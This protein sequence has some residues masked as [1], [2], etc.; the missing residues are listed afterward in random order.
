[1]LI[2]NIVFIFCR[3]PIFVGLRSL[4]TMGL[5]SH[6]VT[7]CV[8]VYGGAFLAQNYEIG[9]VPSLSELAKQFEGYLQNYTKDSLKDFKKDK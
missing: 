4:Q 3:N 6:L 7:M 5:F 2:T 1:M 9:K 8:G